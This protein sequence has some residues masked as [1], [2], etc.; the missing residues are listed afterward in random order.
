MKSLSSLP[1][2]DRRRFLAGCAGAA[3]S[4]VCLSSGE[5]M[6]SAQ[7]TPQRPPAF[8]TARRLLP[9]PVFD[10]KP[11]Y[12]EAYWKAWELA[13]RNF[14]VPSPESGFVSPFIDAAFNQNIFLWDTCF[15]TMFCNYGHPLVPGIGSLDNFY[16]KQHEDGEICREIVR[17]TG[18]DYQEWVNREDW[19]LFS[20]WG[21]VSA[22][23]RERKPVRV[24]YVGRTP[25]A[26]NA[27]LTLDALNHPI[28]AWAE[29]ESFRVTG[30][31]DRLRRVWE[32]LCRYYRAFQ[33]YVRQG[34]GL[35][36]TDWASMDNSPRNEFLDQG[37]VA[38]DTSAEMVLFAR[39]MAAIGKIVGKGR[40]ARL[41]LRDADE[42]TACINR[43]MWDPET[44]FYF[45]L[46]RN[47]RRIPVRTIAAFWTLLAGVASGDRLEGLTA[48]LKNS[49]SFARMHRVPTCSAAEK[50]FDP[51]GGYWRGAVWSPTT[52][53]VVRGLEN[54]S[55][56]DLAREIALNHLQLVTAVF[57]SSGTFWENYAPDSVSPGTP[58]KRDFVGWSGIAPIAYLLEYAV[59]LRP[60][61]ERNELIWRLRSRQRTGCERFRFN[62]HT[63]DLI[64]DPDP[65][66]G[67]TRIV[68]V[69]DGSFRLKVVVAGSE[70][71]H[72]IRSGKQ[73]LL[74][75]VAAA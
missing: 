7:I 44:K 29:I 46:D 35:Y 62:G 23:S 43:L 52:T 49:A 47:G 9:S 4:V 69:S 36:M 8:E 71:K 31:R 28:F 58:A 14:H 57:K 39:Q 34:N 45:D 73:T 68:V 61:A 42:V 20:R 13:F 72:D 5:Q 65:G 12:V 74:V 41:F 33:N 75:G 48:E 50:V 67:R 32:P 30:D 24:T 40:A 6:L 54:Y 51:K 15:M 3:S 19:P 63:V 55:Q 64:A 56:D 70:F 2:I 18:R 59:G 27:R 11:E 16:A 1:A 66:N 17:N 37:G 38:V 10:E 60:D 26:V 22:G 25:P 21:W 53:M